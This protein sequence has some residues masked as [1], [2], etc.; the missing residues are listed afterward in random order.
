M[1]CVGQLVGDVVRAA[2]TE[3]EVE[4]AVVG[5]DVA[6]PLAVP[7]GRHEVLLAL[8]G[9]EVHRHPA[10]FA[11]GATGHLEHPAAPHAHAR[12]G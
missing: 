8:V 9:E 3:Q 1:S 6:D 5:A 2:A 4:P 10:R 7:T 12:G 11:G